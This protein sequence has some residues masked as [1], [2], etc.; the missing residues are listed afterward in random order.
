MLYIS[1]SIYMDD[2]LII[3]TSNIDESLDRVRTVL[4]VLSESG[5]SFNLEKCTFMKKKVEYLGYEV[6]RGEIRPIPKKINSL[7]DLPHPQTITQLRQFVGLASYFRHFVP[8]FGPVMAPL[9]V[10]IITGLGSVEWKHEHE[11][12]WQKIVTILAREPV[13][14]IFDPKSPIGLHTDASSIGNGG[15]LIQK[16]DGKIV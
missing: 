9:H 14:T 4:R 11:I 8:R 15:F 13:L 6:S 5:F 3:G 7:V 2:I 16:W 10:L 12:I 1:T